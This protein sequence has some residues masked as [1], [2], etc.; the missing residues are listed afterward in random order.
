[1]SQVIT[2]R[3]LLY[4]MQASTCLCFSR[5][6]LC[7]SDSFMNTSVIA[8]VDSDSWKTMTFVGFTQFSHREQYHSCIGSSKVWL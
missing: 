1:M 6:M 5:S 4:S 8:E 7:L 3:L 2:V